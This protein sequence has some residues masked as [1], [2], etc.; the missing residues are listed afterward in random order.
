MKKAPS[1]VVE[2]AK[3]SV[4]NKVTYPHIDKDFYSP[5]CVLVCK[6]ICGPNHRK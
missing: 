1:S 2:L 4:C 6:D 3:G 5:C